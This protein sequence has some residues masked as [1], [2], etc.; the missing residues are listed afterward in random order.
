MYI[1]WYSTLDGRGRSF[2]SPRNE[3][4][5]YSN[6]TRLITDQFYSRPSHLL[7]TS[8][9]QSQVTY[10]PPV[11]LKAKS[12]TYH[13]FYS[14][15]SHLLTTSSTHIL[16]YTA[17][18]LDYIYCDTNMSQHLITSDIKDFACT[19]H[20]AVMQTIFPEVPQV[21]ILT[22]RTYETKYL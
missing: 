4:Q 9:T 22:P 16:P 19:D 17:R 1:T 6:P 15:P 8:S 2:N 18:R 5:F 7:T 20:R 10:L 11:L 14:K 13:Q 21:G 12:L 3:F